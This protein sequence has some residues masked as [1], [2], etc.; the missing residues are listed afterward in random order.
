MKPQNTLTNNKVYI[1]LV[2]WNGMTGSWKR[3]F[4]VRA[5][6]KQGICT[7]RIL[8]PKR[9]CLREVTL[10]VVRQTLGDRRYHFTIAPECRVERDIAYAF[11]PLLVAIGMIPTG[12]FCKVR[13]WEEKEGKER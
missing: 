2:H 6:K 12:V 8:G 3:F 4:V 9:E 10:R 5:E 11:K 7:L 1:E 13:L